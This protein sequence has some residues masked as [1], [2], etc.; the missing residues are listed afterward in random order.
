MVQTAFVIGAGASVEFGFPTGPG[1]QEKIVHFLKVG[2]FEEYDLNRHLMRVWD[3]V[4]Q[5]STI[6]YPTF[7]ETCRW[8]TAAIPFSQ[9]IDSFLET[10][11]GTDPVVGM[12]GKYAISSIIASCEESCALRVNNA[13]GIIPNASG[14]WLT[15]FWKRACRGVSVEDSSDALSD[16][17]FITFNYDRCFERYM[18]SAYQTHFRSSDLEAQDFVKSLN[19]THV[20]GHLGQDSGDTEFGN[21]NVPEFSFRASNL[22]KTYSEQVDEDTGRNVGDLIDHASVIIFIGFSFAPI[23][24]NFLSSVVKSEGRLKRVYGTSYGLSPYDKERAESWA[25]SCF[26]RGNVGSK[27]IDRTAADFFSY[28]NLMF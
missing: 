25:D 17:S 4:Q 14:S 13:E 7:V 15:E 16:Y 3:R 8:M 10:H 24:T 28:Y 22:I 21:L 5:S 26:R 6:S 1:L 27:L 9:S 2:P 20:Y 12:I 11:S 19:I 23:N 18:R